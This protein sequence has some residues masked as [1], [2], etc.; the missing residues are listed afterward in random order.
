MS[1]EPTR[2]WPGGPADGQPARP[3][4]DQAYPDRQAGGEPAADQP[5]QPADR[6]YAAG[7]VP[8]PGPGQT[9][10]HPGVYPS[11]G[12]PPGQAGHPGQPPYGQPPGQ[13]DYGQPPPG[14]PYRQPPPGPP[15]RQ[16]PPGPPYGQP[17]AGYGQPMAGQQGT[18]QQ[19]YGPP[20]QAQPG[21]GQPGYG[22]PGYGQ[23]G[24]GY[25]GYGRSGPEPGGI[26]LRPLA[27]GEILS[28]AF[29][30]IRQNPT[31]TLGLSAI[32]LTCYGIASAAVSLALRGVLNNLHLSAGQTLTH[33]QARH[34]LFEVF[35]IVLPS[36]LGLF[37]VAFLV[38]LILTGLL[39]VVIGRGVLGRKLSMGEAWRIAL[40]RLPAILGAVVLTALCII[41]PWAVVAVL[42]VILALA[43]LPPAAIAVG[44]IGGIASICLTIWFSVMLS[45]ATP[46]VVLERQGPARALA[47]S[48]RL[49]RRSFWRVFGILL[50]AALV[51]AFAGFILQLPFSLIGALAGGSGGVFGLPATQTLAAVIIGAVGSIVAGAVTRPVSAGVTVLLYLDMRMR[52]EGLDLALQGV[53]NGQQLTGDEFET[54]WRPPAA[55][56]PPAGVP[57]TW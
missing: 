20:G 5:G 46:A 9:P 13:Q 36:F 55:G 24:Y 26:P 38:E 22:Q 11:Y 51:V 47:R 41:G 23:P 3:G 35:A 43:H 52:K 57:P 14:P 6:A 37:V 32:V 21:Y 1:D 31:A 17:P 39:T 18:Y 40:P 53:A 33:A 4:A 7:P 49:V 10:G 25:P 56:Q 8:P 27:V 30:S 44:V 34:L 12:P 48:W 50:L 2:D 15:Y 19:G 45:L 29:T 16:Q 54:V 42:A 28:G